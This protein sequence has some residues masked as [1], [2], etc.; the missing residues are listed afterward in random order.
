MVYDTVFNRHNNYHGCYM[1]RIIANICLAI[2]YCIISLIA[3]PFMVIG[4]VGEMIE[5][6]KE[7]R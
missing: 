7:A 5:R 4:V 2:M 3:L 1:K 6:N